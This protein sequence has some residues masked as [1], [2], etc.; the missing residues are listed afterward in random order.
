MIHPEIILDRLARNEPEFSSY[1]GKLDVWRVE[2]P[3]FRTLLSTL[4]I[5]INEAL[6]LENANA[7]GG[8]EHPPFHF[9]YLVAPD[10]IKNAH[11]FQREGFSFIVVT[12]PLV[13]TTLDVAQRLSRSAIVLQLLHLNL[14]ALESEIL[15]GFFA[16]IQMLFLISHEYTHHVHEHLSRRDQSGVWT[17]FPHRANCGNID[18]QAEELDADGYAAYLV[19]THLL[20]GERRKSALIQLGRADMP[21]TDCDELLLSCFFL[22]VI[23]FFCTFWR[24]KIDPSSVHQLTH[25]TPRVRIKYVI[26]VAKMWCGQFDSVSQSWFSP[27]RLQDIF[28][29][30]SDGIGKTT[31]QHWDADIS[32]L[33]SADGDRYYQM[34]FERFEAMRAG[35]LERLDHNLVASK[36]LCLGFPGLKTQI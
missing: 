8:V 33:S 11:A 26:E 12:L 27:S 6:R 22:A 4:Q 7:S 31:R 10:E 17:E 25:P 13:V 2:P 16:Q 30:A 15:Q 34:L 9:D 14:G 36:S 1:A 28:C 24:E 21:A 29:A 5:Q 32:F 20:R 3:S 35:A 23:A 18:S 19:L